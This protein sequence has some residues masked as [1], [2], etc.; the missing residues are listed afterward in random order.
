MAFFL[1]LSFAFLA[2]L[3]LAWPVLRRSRAAPNTVPSQDPLSEVALRRSRIYDDIKTLVLDHELGNIPDQEY[4]EKLAA[5]R[6]DAARAIR[7]QE[8]LHQAQAS[9]EDDL[10]R[11]V[12][13]LRRSWGSVKETT[14][15][16]VC[17]REVDAVA[18]LCPRCEL[19]LGRETASGETTSAEGK[20]SWA[21]Q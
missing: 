4:E 13:E 2:I 7:D 9:L 18:D 10:E 14:I 5:Y 11:E 15:C 12:L 19:P 16:A 20:A 8:Q 1:G 6:I 21:E 3:L 17:G